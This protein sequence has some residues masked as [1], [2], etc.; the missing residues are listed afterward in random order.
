MVFFCWLFVVVFFLLG[1]ETLTA[2]TAAKVANHLVTAT[3]TLAT[4]SSAQVL[5]DQGVLGIDVATEVV[6]ALEVQVASG[7]QAWE[8][9]A[10]GVDGHVRLELGA[11]GEGLGAGGAGIRL[12]G[13]RGR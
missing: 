6:L 5:L 9:E 3:E 13:A 4:S 10:V 11:G 1:L 7:V 2:G 8:G 12:C